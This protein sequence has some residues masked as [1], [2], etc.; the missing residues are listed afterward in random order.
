MDACV[1]WWQRQVAKQCIPGTPGSWDA[2]KCCLKGEK[3]L[4]LKLI[5]ELLGLIMLGLFPPVNLQEVGQHV[6]LLELVCIRDP[7]CFLLAF[8]LEPVYCG[9]DRGQHGCCFPLC[10]INAG[11]SQEGK[12]VTCLDLLQLH[13]FQKQVASLPCDAAELS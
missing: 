2:I 3:V 1:A 11:S 10:L 5:W 8:N 13:A 12:S 7:F 6:N 4:L 9:T